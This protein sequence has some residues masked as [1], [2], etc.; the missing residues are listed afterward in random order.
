MLVA[1]EEAKVLL[2][3]CGTPLLWAEELDIT[4]HIKQAVTLLWAQYNFSCLLYAKSLA[5][6]TFFQNM[7][8]NILCSLHYLKRGNVVHNFTFIA[9]F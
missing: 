9:Y 6:N 2:M 1:N 8:H 3:P 7:K 4:H 5:R